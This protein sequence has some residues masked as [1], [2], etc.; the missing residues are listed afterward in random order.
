VIAAAGIFW[1]LILIGGTVD[2]LTTRN[3]MPAELQTAR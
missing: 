1:L 3:H 2:D